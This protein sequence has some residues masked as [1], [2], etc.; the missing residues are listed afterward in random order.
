MTI[1]FQMLIF[2]RGTHSA[3]YICLSKQTNSV[4]KVKN[5]NSSFIFFFIFAGL[6]FLN[7]IISHLV[8][9]AAPEMFSMK[10]VP[11]SR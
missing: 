10:N 5:G 9:R 2:D 8:V 4:I 3:A 1:Y 7:E 6:F 11:P